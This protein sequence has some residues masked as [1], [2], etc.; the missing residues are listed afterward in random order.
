MFIENMILT[1]KHIL[2]KKKYNVD[3]ID[4]QRS[5][6]DSDVEEWSKISAED[7]V[8]NQDADLMY[9][10]DRVIT[11]NKNEAANTKEKEYKNKNK[12][13][14]DHVDNTAQY[15]KF[16]NA[17]LAAKQ[18][19]LMDLKKQSEDFEKE[20]AKLKPQDQRTKLDLDLIN[21]NE[22]KSDDIRKVL[23]ILEK[24]RDEAKSRVEH[25]STQLS[26]AN[27]ELEKKNLEM[28]NAKSELMNI[29]NNELS[30]KNET[31][32]EE[33]TMGTIHK[34]LSS[35]DSKGEA[36][37]IYGAINSLVVLLNSK[38]QETLNELN[39]I[40]SEFNKMKIEYDKAIQKIN[41]EK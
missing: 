34:E 23:S 19:K 39:S 31:T 8:E 41:K 3:D 24:D 18:S 15:L 14:K 32:K 12:E 16:V 17:H 25:F 38:N 6:H 29:K 27:K 33:N 36:G 40:K 2:R 37:K 4:G 5:D 9:V 30:Q 1:D 28:E 10:Q 7:Q 22:I 13:F 26:Q 21:Y 11:F 35:L 20:V